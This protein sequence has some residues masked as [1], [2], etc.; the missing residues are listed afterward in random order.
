MRLDST[1]KR[2]INLYQRDLPVCE[3]PYLE[4]SRQ[5]GISE[6]EVIDR[7]LALQSDKVISR[8]GPIFDSP[9]VVPEPVLVSPCH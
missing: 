4:M 3:R 1:D 8:V 9:T 7:L 6:K 2:L 5:L